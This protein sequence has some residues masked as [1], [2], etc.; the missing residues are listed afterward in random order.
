MKESSDHQGNGDLTSFSSIPPSQRMI[1]ACAGAFFASLLNKIVFFRNGVL[2]QVCPI[3]PAGPSHCEH[4]VNITS[5]AT[6]METAFNIAKSEGTFGLWRGL[7][8]TVMMVVP[9]TVIYY[10]GYDF[11]KDR[12]SF[13]LGS[14]KDVLAPMIAGVTARKMAS[15]VKNAVKQSGASSLWRGLG[16]TLLRDVPFSACYWAGY[17]YFK[18]KLSR[19]V[20]EKN[21]NIATFAAG[22]ISGS[23]V[24]TATTPFDVVKTRLQVDMGENFAEKQKIPSTWSVIRDIWKLHGWNGLFAGAL[25]ERLT[26]VTARVAKITPACAIM[27]AVPYVLCNGLM[28]HK[29]T[30]C[31]ETMMKN[32]R[33]TMWGTFVNIMKNEGPSALYRGLPPT[34][35]MAIP[36]T[37]IFFTAYDILKEK[38]TPHLGKRQDVLAPMLSAMLARVTVVT[39]I[40]PMELVRT[41]M[42]AS[43]TAGYGELVRIVYQEARIS[44]VSTLWRGLGTTLMRD[45]PFS[46]FYWAGYENFKKRFN[47][48]TNGKYPNISNFSA[49]ATSGMIVAAATTPFDVVKTHL[50]VDM[51]ETNSKNGSQKVPSMFAIMN[52][53]RQQ[54]GV[55]G[56]Y[57]GVAARVIKVAPASAIMISTYEFCKD[58]FANKNRLT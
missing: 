53:I 42:Q 21:R 43:K 15:I 36:S 50:Q 5:R 49:G 26:S 55:R 40:S 25:M 12:L 13:R 38:L 18:R 20:G 30:M 44:G 22:A 47:T 7:S 51:G 4:Q 24:A 16:P 39:A 6:A 56:L 34:L 31:P 37:M 19:S 48:L 2:S 3:C 27:I 14:Y 41:K 23:I 11:L 45:L 9:A 32:C 57:T 8:P 10:T 1:S 29:C 33:T 58:Y 46:A 35:I 28:D 54:Y 17:E 52:N